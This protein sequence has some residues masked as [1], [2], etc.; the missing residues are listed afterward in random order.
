MVL[1]GFVRFYQKW[2]SPYRLPSCRFAPTC[3]DYAVEALQQHGAFKGGALAVL[4][5]VKCGP[6]HPGGWDPVPERK[7]SDDPCVSFAAEASDEVK[8]SA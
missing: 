1:L 7:N 6:W 2:V 8:R 4:R 5:L 3:S